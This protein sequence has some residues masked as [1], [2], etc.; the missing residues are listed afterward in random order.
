M[1]TPETPRKIEETA[2]PK[3]RA[4]EG[5]LT[6]EDLK[7]RELSMDDMGAV[8][9]GDGAGPIVFFRTNPSNQKTRF[10]QL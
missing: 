8:I 9:G 7:A 10:G 6:L 1:N 5:E 3:E 4:I 2:K